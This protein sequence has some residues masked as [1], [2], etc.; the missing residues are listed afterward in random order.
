[1][2]EFRNLRIETELLLRGKHF[3]P[4]ELAFLQ[5]VVS[6]IVGKCV[7]HEWFCWRFAPVVQQ[8]EAQFVECHCLFFENVFLDVPEGISEVRNPY[9][10][11]TE[12]VVGCSVLIKIPLPVSQALR[13]AVQEG[14]RT[15]C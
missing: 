3:H 10:L 13:K 15:C 6:L 7:G 4:P 9:V 2:P 5:E 8:D 11:R 12:L 1:M 14:A